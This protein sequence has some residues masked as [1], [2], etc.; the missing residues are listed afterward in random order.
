M[1]LRL[2]P[3]ATVLASCVATPPTA[4]IE[5]PPIELAGRTAGAPQQ[6]VPIEQ[7]DSLRVSD[8]NRHTL[9]YGSGKTIWADRLA[10][11]CSMS[12]NDLLV[13]EPIGSHYCRGDIV[14]SIDRL[15]R[16]PGPSC[17]LGN[18]VPYTR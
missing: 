13:T 4:G 16:I 2:A 10:S 9:L 11:E 3:I 14:R 12:A 8:N 17:V 15:S 7:S 5:R 18:F 6:C 1:K